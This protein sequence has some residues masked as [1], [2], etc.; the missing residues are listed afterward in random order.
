MGSESESDSTTVLFYD[1][2]D[3][4]ATTSAGDI[5]L[6]AV[7]FNSKGE[8]VSVAG[9]ELIFLPPDAV[10]D[11]VTVPPPKPPPKVEEDDEEDD[12]EETD[13]S[14][15]SSSESSGSSSGSSGSSSSSQRRASTEDS[16][17]SKNDQLIIISTVATMAILV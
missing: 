5:A 8:K 16:S 2:E 1:P 12:E 13:T 7:I 17:T 4:P 14:S 10:K 11:G 3:L 15:S 9:K 6:P